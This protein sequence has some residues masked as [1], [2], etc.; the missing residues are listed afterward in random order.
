MKRRQFMTG[1]LA[2]VA[3]PA[4]ARPS[5]TLYATPREILSP[6]FVD[7]AGRALTLGDFRGRIV[8]LNICATWCPPC[9]EEMPTLD[10][11]Q[12][13]L[14]G[15]DFAVVALSVDAGGLPAV[16]QFY[17]QAGLRN[18]ALYLGDQT[19]T[20]LAVGAYGIPTT[21][22]IDRQGRE[23]GRKVGPAQWDSAGNVALVEDLIAGG[24]RVLQET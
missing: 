16:R 24:N 15:E 3:T 10:R 22:L 11:L 9:R 13:R 7:A 21:L 4:M 20:T 8:L 17:Q 14:G 18:L 12:A 6:S 23:L 1:A 5:I 19:R 2:L